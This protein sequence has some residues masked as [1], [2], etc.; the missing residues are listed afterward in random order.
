MAEEEIVTTSVVERI[1]KESVGEL[2]AGNADPHSSRIYSGRHKNVL[3]VRGSPKCSTTSIQDGVQFVIPEIYQPYACRCLRSH[4]TLH[5]ALSES[6][7]PGG[8]V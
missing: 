7:S 8:P 2:E 3:E 6:D 4:H 1:G 5:L